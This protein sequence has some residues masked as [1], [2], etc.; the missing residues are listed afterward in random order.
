VPFFAVNVCSKTNHK[1]QL[2]MDA[3]QI[4]LAAW[5]SGFEDW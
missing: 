5:L 3:R 4:E 2:A 1:E